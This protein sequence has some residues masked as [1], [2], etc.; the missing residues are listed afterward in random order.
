M[1]YLRELYANIFVIYVKGVVVYMKIIK[2]CRYVVA[3]LL[4]AAMVSAGGAAYADRFVTPVPKRI[5]SEDG[6]RVFIFNP[7]GEANYPAMGVYYNTTPL[8]LLYEI[9]LGPAVYE[10]DFVFS[11]SF[12]NFVFVPIVSQDI[13]L[14]FFSDGVLLRSYSI[15]DLVR[16]MDYVA[17]T[18]ST[19]H[20]HDRTRGSNVDASGN[21]FT[22]V[23][24]DNIIYT[25]NMQ[26]GDIVNSVQLFHGTPSMWALEQVAEAVS[27]NLVPTG[28]QAGFTQA[29]TRA[30]FAA[31]AVAVYEALAG[32]EIEGRREFND[33][34][35][36]NVQ[37]MGYL[38]IVIGVGD[39]NFNPDN[40][41]TRQEAA[42]MLSRL[43][44]R[45]AD[46][47][48]QSGLAVLLAQSAASD[49]EIVYLDGD[50]IS[51]WAL[52]SVREMTFIGLMHGTGNNTFSP[53][54]IFTREQSIAVMLR[55]FKS[56]DS[57]G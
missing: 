43:S 30:E 57:V 52:D 2:H 9:D 36:I 4:V 25:F 46:E 6:S 40:T 14:Q 20:W 18:V 44:H 22:V 24:T 38:D 11:P 8:V 33:S 7:L 16:N 56:F 54:G 21:R 23:T 42:V 28:L 53:Q 12:S 48:P 29:I 34:A 5:V 35:D 39:G 26:T 49:F 37:K 32:N 51:F 55:L 10:Q 50:S 31:L 15:S 19:A 47:Y 1:Y 13:A 3:F 27:A 41:I 45:L 17:F